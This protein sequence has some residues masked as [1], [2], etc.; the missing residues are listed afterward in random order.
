MIPVLSAIVVGALL[1]WAVAE[2]LIARADRI[3]SRLRQR[4]TELE[5]YR[6]ETENRREAVKLLE[7]EAAGL[8][9]DVAKLDRLKDTASE[10]VHR[11]EA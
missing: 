9:E 7:R 1:V 5:Q 11:S 6:A 10:P 4:L 3:K 2:I 8:R